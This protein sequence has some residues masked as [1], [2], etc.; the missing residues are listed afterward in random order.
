MATND[1]PTQ[2]QNLAD[3]LGQLTKQHGAQAI[4]DLMDQAGASNDMTKTE[5][6]TAGL[7][8]TSVVPGSTPPKLGPDGGLLSPVEAFKQASMSADDAADEMSRLGAVGF[9]QEVASRR[10]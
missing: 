9:I 10:P 8:A 3:A 2:P 6:A 5:P 7:T 1:L 4:Q